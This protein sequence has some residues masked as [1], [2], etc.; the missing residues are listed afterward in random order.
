MHYINRWKNWDDIF[1]DIPIAVF[2]RPNQ[3]LKAGLSL[4]AQKYQKYRFNTRM[5]SRVPMPA[6]S[7]QVGPQ[8]K[9]S[10]TLLRNHVIY[11]GGV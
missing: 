11:P 2:S 6:W 10:S 7:I 8:L 1:M 5:L 4:A 3:Q 9:I